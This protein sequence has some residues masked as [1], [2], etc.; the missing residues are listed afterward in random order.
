[1]S[2][3]KLELNITKLSEL[4]NEVNKKVKAFRNFMPSKAI[5]NFI[6][7]TQNAKILIKLAETTL[8]DARENAST[9]KELSDISRWLEN[10][11]KQ[12]SDIKN[13]LRLL[14]KEINYNANIHPK[15]KEYIEK[16]KRPKTIT[17]EEY[18]KIIN[19]DNSNTF[20]KTKK[21]EKVHFRNSNNSNYNSE[22]K[23]S[24]K[25]QKR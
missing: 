3:E 2:I 4:T 9:E 5:E 24:I 18:S 20:D 6:I 7:I 13:N 19:N 25:R 8:S 21:S 17:I 14:E 15:T 22:T 23:H 10:A 11:H 12:F 1:M 16:K